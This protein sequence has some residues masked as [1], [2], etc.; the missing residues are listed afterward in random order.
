MERWREMYRGTEHCAVIHVIV[1]TT[2]ATRGRHSHSAH[3]AAVSLINLL[4]R[5]LPNTAPFWNGMVEDRG[6]AARLCVR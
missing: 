2:T 3:A 4:Y 1:I 5:V 6:S